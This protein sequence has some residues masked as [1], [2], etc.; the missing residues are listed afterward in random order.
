MMHFIS[1]RSG[2]YLLTG[3][4]EHKAHLYDGYI[5]ILQ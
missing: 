3:K 5:R 2:K 4:P 1:H